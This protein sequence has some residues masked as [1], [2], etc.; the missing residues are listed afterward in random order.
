MLVDLLFSE[1]R[2]TYFH[3]IK[4]F[5]RPILDYEEFNISEIADIILKQ[6]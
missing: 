5:L 4:D 2:D 1:L 6:V 3:N